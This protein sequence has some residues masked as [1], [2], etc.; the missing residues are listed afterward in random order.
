MG[1]MEGGYEREG[2]EGEGRRCMRQEGG[3]G[4]IDEKTYQSSPTYTK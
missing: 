2:V 3:G 4:S 1:V